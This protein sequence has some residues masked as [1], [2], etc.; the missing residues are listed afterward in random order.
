MCKKRGE[1]S[2]GSNER[3]CG[4]ACVAQQTPVTSKVWAKSLL[5]RS[6]RSDRVLRLS[7]IQRAGRNNPLVIVLADACAMLLDATR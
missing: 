7:Q 1:S 6:L 4:G 3:P 5:V 2:E